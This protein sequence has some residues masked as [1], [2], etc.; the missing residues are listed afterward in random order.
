QCYHC[1]SNR[2]I[3]CPFDQSIFCL[4]IVCCI[5]CVLVQ[6]DALLFFSSTFISLWNLL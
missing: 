2:I 5:C 6:D 1:G 4:L 3:I